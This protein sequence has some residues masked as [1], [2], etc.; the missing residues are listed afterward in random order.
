M[1]GPSLW[2]TLHVAAPS[3]VDAFNAVE[4]ILLGLDYKQ[5]ELVKSIDSLSFLPATDKPPTLSCHAKDLLLLK[6][7]SNATAQCLGTAFSVLQDLGSRATA[8]T[9]KIKNA[10]N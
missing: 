1:S 4:D 6:A 5:E 10:G 9:P 7:T 3:P 8:Q 2:E